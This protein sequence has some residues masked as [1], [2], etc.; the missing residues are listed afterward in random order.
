MYVTD[1]ISVLNQCCCDE[2][3]I[4]TT[5]RRP[6]QSKKY[7]L[8]TVWRQDTIT[9]LNVIAR[10][11]PLFSPDLWLLGSKLINAPGCLEIINPFSWS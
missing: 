1:T 6:R 7:C 9:R 11:H 10:A 2:L 8:K 4:K 5:T 3:M